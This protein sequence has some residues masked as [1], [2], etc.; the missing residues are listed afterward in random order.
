MISILAIVSVLPFWPRVTLNVT[1]PAMVWD[2]PLILCEA[3]LFGLPLS[4]VSRSGTRVKDSFTREGTSQERFTGESGSQS[5]R[6]PMR[7]VNVRIPDEHTRPERGLHRSRVSLRRRCVLFLS[8][9]KAR[10][11]RRESRSRTAGEARTGEGHR[12]L[13]TSSENPLTSVV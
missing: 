1:E 3:A 8:L 6:S 11:L 5:C 10:S 2:V 7:T 4:L 13:P 12:G 9:R